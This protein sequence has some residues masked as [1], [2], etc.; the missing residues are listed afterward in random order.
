[1]IE[2]AYDLEMLDGAADR[3][4]AD[5]H[6][7]AF[8]LPPGIAPEQWPLEPWSG[9]PL[10]HVF[11]L[12]LPQDHRCHGPDLVA[13]S[14]FAVSPEHG[15]GEESDAMAK[16]VLGESEPSDPRFRAFWRPPARRHPRLTRMKDLTLGY[17]HA[18]ILLTRAEFEAPFCLPPEIAREGLGMDR[19]QCAVSAQGSDEEGWEWRYAPVCPEPAWLKNGS[20]GAYASNE[21][22]AGEKTGLAV[23]RGLRWSARA[24]DPNAGKVPRDFWITAVTSDYTP[25][26]YFDENNQYRLHAWGEGHACDHIGGTMRPVQN[27][28]PFSPFY[29]EFGEGVGGCNFGG[30]CAQLD[31]RDMKFDWACG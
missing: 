26:F 1:M 4:G 13:L 30:G 11:T 16:A 2:R 15:E 17:D 10:M 21:V 18:V 14:L 6:G 5:C 28:P 8:G 3:G 23:H 20:L 7:W 24:N 9:Y 25:H 31:F 29:V 12:L 27:T 22:R 19:A